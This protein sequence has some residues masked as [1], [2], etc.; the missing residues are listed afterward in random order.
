MYRLY[1][2]RNIFVRY[3]AEQIIFSLEMYEANGLSLIESITTMQKG[4][5]NP[6]LVST[7][8]NIHRLLSPGC[9]KSWTQGWDSLVPSAVLLLIIFLPR[10]LFIIKSLRHCSCTKHNIMTPLPMVTSPSWQHHDVII[11]LAQNNNA[12]MLF[13]PVG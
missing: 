11:Y 1:I 12:K 6:I 13:H 2:A 9:C 4:Q 7:I 10:L 8:C 3:E 5:G